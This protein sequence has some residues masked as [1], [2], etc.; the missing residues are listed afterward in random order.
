MTAC[1]RA[2][3]V[4]VRH[5]VLSFVMVVTWITSPDSGAVPGLGSIA[6]QGMES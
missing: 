3:G 4:L 2:F 1:R 6:S 5:R